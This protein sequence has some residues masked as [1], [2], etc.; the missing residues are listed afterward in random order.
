MKNLNHP[1]VLALFV[2][3]ALML[4][5][6]EKDDPENGPKTVYGN[7][8]SLGDGT[9]STYISQDANGNPTEVGVILTDGAM[10]NLPEEMVNFVL[11]LP[12]NGATD[13]YTHVLLDWNPQGHEPPGVYDLPHFD[14]HFYII[15]EAERDAIGPMDMEAFAKA[16]DNMYV[17]TDYF[18]SEGGVPQMGA[19]WL[20]ATAPEFNGQ[21][22]KNTFIWGSYDG[23]FIFWEPMVTRDYL[24]TQPDDITAMKLPEAYQKEGWYGTKYKVSHNSS[25]GRYEIALTDL[26]KREASSMK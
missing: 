23:E 18:L 13:F 3:G 17:P 14:L 26:V 5:S 19:H 8:E 21:V 2:A 15:S 25:E 22:F 12:E 9:V 24:L 4:V 10:D 7:L 16:P 1:V 6:C 11:E 20:D